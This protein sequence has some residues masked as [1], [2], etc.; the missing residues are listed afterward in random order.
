MRRLLAIALCLSL[1]SMLPL[2]AEAAIARN[3][4]TYVACST[5][6][7]TLSHAPAGTN[8]FLSVCVTVWHYLATPTISAATWN[9]LPLT[10]VGTV[11]NPSCADKCTTSLYALANPG[12]ATANVSITFASPFGGVY[13]GAVVGAVSYTGVD[14]TTPVGTAVTAIGSGS[15]ASVTVPS[16]SSEVVMDCLGSLASGSPPTVASGQTQNWSTFDGGG[17]IH[18]ASGYVSG[19]PSTVMAWTLSGSPQWSMLGVPI[20]PAG[21]GGGGGSTPG[22]Q[23]VISWQDNSDNEKCFH[24]QW[25]TDQSYP[26]WV[27]INACLPPNTVSYA[28][29][30]GTSTGDCYQL[31]ATNDGG[32]KGFTLPACS[33]IAPPPPPPPPPPSSTIATPFHFDFEE[34]LL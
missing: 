27:D 10:L 3:S 28:H 5:N 31:E 17:S 7:C 6:P 20:K 8:P 21:G 34:D 2:A 14:P 12:A 18:S 19:A 1:S 9:G 23:R 11:S 30:I 33:A 26:N 25:R 16:N 29:D 22:T 13:N 24:L 32:S 15:P 4:A